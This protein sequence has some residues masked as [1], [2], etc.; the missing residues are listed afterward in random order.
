MGNTAKSI[1]NQ[2]L[3][4]SPAERI[5]VAEQILSSLDQPDAIMDQLWSA[6]SESRID[7]YEKGELTAISAEDVLS[8]YKKP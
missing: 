2:A 6:E 8:K 5:L 1:I 3:D 7:A 4:L